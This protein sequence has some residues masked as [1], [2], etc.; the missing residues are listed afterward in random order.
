MEKL[1]GSWFDPSRD[2]EGLTF[3]VVGDTTVLAYW[4]TY[5]TDGSQMWLLGV[6]ALDEESIADILMERTSGGKF[7]A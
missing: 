7:G 3:E 2:G 1:T 5:D 4:F 6:D